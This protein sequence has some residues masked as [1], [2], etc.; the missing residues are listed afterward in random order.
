MAGRDISAV[1]PPHCPRQHHLACTQSGSRELPRRPAHAA[2]PPPAALF[3]PSRALSTQVRFH[4]PSTIQPIM[5]AQRPADLALADPIASAHPHSPPASSN[6]SHTAVTLLQSKFRQIA[7]SR[8]IHRWPWCQPPPFRP[9]RRHALS[10]PPK[11]T[12]ACAA[13]ASPTGHPPFQPFHA[14]PH[15]PPPAFNFLANNQ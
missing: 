15:P 14:K 9:A 4:S 11:T 3:S 12:T 10:T 7:I 5:A 13:R 8:D 1:A 2:R 6:C